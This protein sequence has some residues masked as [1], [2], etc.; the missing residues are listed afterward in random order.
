MSYIPKYI[1]KRMFA[2]DAVKKVAGGLEITMTS[3]ISP[4]S[5]D[6]LPEDAENY[7]EALIDGKPIKKEKMKKPM[8]MTINGE[9]KSYARR[10][11]ARKG[12]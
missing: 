8:K 5:V 11:Q 12:S 3:V 9:K 2:K 1:L 4:F 10:V 7:I 6:E